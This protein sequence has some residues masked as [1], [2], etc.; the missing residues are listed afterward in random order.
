MKRCKRCHLNFGHYPVIHEGKY[1]EVCLEC[2]IEL[3]IGKQW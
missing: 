3:K 1:V 2:L